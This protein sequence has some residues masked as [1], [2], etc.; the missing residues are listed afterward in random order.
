MP[1]GTLAEAASYI[2][3]QAK[4]LSVL[5]LLCAIGD[6]NLSGLQES[7]RKSWQ[8][9][10]GGW[11]GQLSLFKKDY[12]TAKKR[13]I[14]GQAEQGVLSGGWKAYRCLEAGDVVLS[15][16]W[17]RMRLT[18]Q[19]VAYSAKERRIRQAYEGQGG[20]IPV[21][22]WRNWP[23]RAV[24]LSG[25]PFDV[26][27]GASLKRS[28]ATRIKDAEAELPLSKVKLNWKRLSREGRRLGTIRKQRLKIQA[29]LRKAIED[30][31]Q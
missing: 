16:R 9:A 30:A 18:F 11:H 6:Q 26:D 3:A 25:I 24:D 12:Y 2:S 15:E 22:P 31:I 7:A 23:Q 8:K 20:S 1:K 4:Q 29:A 13:A 28:R 5:A 17:R 19:S 27:V 14:T 10:R 21:R